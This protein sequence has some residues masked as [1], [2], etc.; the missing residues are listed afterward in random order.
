MSIYPVRINDQG[1]KIIHHISILNFGELVGRTKIKYETKQGEQI[2]TIGNIKSQPGHFDVFKL[3]EIDL[4][5]LIGYNGEK[6]VELNYN[7]EA[8][9]LL[10]SRFSPVSFL[11]H[12][13][14]NKILIKPIL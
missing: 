6:I 4:N 13:L 8:G 9:V 10:E 11:K 3:E 5:N 1:K 12:E 14:E 2:E 7:I